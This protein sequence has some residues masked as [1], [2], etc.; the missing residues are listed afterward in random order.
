[1]MRL[2]VKKE[3]VDFLILQFSHV[4]NVITFFSKTFELFFEEFYALYFRDIAFFHVVSFFDK[5]DES[6][7]FY[8]SLAKSFLVF[9]L[10]ILFKVKNLISS[11]IFRYRRI[12]NV[13]IFEIIYQIQQKI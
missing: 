3:F 8:E 12:F 5:M 10:C 1:L 13:E 9:R 4:F 6:L 7:R 11:S 2:I